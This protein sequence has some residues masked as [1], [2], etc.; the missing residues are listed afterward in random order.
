MSRTYRVHAGT[1]ER[2]ARGQRP[3]ALL[4]LRGAA[5]DVAAACEADG[6]SRDQG[7]PLVLRRRAATPLGD[8]E[9]TLDLRAKSLTVRAS[10]SAELTGEGYDVAD[11]E[12]AGTARAWEN[13][14]SRRAAVELEAE[15]AASDVVRAAED[16]LLPGLSAAIQRGY[17]AALKRNAASL[18]AVESVRETVGAGGAPE[19][20]IRV[21]V[22]T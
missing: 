9:V 17:V 22:R 8:A 11:D 21:K 1:V 6:W 16:A 13:A 15:A 18:G 10:S 20:T 7:D 2:S 19:V 4:P 3:V 14:E 5:E 12:E